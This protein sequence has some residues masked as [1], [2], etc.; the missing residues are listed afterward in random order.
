VFYHYKAT[1]E[2]GFEW[3]VKKDEG[4]HGSGR[5]GDHLITTFQCDLCT[6]RN[7]KLRNPS[8][9]DAVLMSCIRQVNL[10]ALWGREVATVGST[11][12]AVDQMLKI[13]NEL[14][15][16]PMLP[17]LG[18]FPV[19]DKMGVAVAIAMIM[20]SRK[21][22]R[23]ADHQQ[24]ET[25]RKLRSGFTNV[26]L[27]SKAET[28]EL[29]T[30]GGDSAKHSLSKC[31]THSLWFERFTK[32][33]LSRMGQIVKQDRAISVEVMLAL[34]GAL[35]TELEEAVR[36][37]QRSLLVSLGA[38][39]AIAFCGS[40]RGQ[41]VFLTDLSGLK[42]YTQENE[43][44]NLAPHV[45]IPLLG[46]FKGEIGSRYHLTPM[47]A[48]TRS[49][50]DVK[51]WVERLVEQKALEGRSNGPAFGDSKG[52]VAQ[53]SVYEVEILDR[54]QMIQNKEPSII[55][56]DILVHEE[57]GISRSFRRGATSEARARGVAPEDIDLI[58]R[59]RTFENAKG[60]R[61]RQSMRDHYSDI[62][63]MIPALLRF[64][65]AL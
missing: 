20:K 45:I 34:L 12:R 60:R 32:G 44:P 47:A 23:Y 3:T 26:Y 53:A 9:Q 24:F 28:E 2:E 51:V 13:W 63:L 52:N 35:E 8:E 10:D 40:F 55:P 14:G 25:I 43:S 22:G 15:V 29:H 65:Q 31:P 33:C 41:E 36:P 17:A 1:D 50:I 39:S 7:L 4:R 21:P 57:Y 59:W 49:G 11:K 64:S 61:P 19:E 62:R 42:K 48:K 56:A 37:P 27:C 46:R 5:D 54:L 18:P 6:F 16:E 58:N 38:F 30:V